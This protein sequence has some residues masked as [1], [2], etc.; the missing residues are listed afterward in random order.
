MQDGLK[1]LD[2]GWPDEVLCARWPEKPNYQHFC[3]D[4]VFR[5]ELPFDRSSLDLLAPALG[6]EHLAALL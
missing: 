1:A 5:H 2:L 4:Q 6:E 3:D